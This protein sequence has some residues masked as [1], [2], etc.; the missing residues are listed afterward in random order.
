MNISAATGKAVNTDPG[1]GIE[2]V[3]RLSDNTWYS[4]ASPQGTWVLT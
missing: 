2:L 3:Y 1:D 4:F